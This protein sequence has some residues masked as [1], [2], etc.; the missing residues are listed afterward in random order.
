MIAVRKAG[1]GF[2]I[3]VPE[4]SAHLACDVI[5]VTLTA[6]E[7]HALFDALGAVLDRD[8]GLP[9]NRRMPAPPGHT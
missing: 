9:K 1:P 7:A 5:G 4:R 2:H 3:D 6:E 8:A